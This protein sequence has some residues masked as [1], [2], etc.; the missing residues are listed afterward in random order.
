MAAVVPRARRLLWRA[1]EAGNFTQCGARQSHPSG[2]AAFE[3]LDVDTLESQVVF[4]AFRPRI[5]VADG[6]AAGL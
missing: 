4:D 5:R 1:A 6:D 3:L 2:Q